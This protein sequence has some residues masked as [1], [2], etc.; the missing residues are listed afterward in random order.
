LKKKAEG[1][2][3]FRKETAGVSVVVTELD[4]S[5]VMG[6][7]A[8]VVPSVSGITIDQDRGLFINLFKFMITCRPILIV[9]LLLSFGCAPS[10]GAST[11]TP[12]LVSAAE[13]AM[14]AYTSQFEGAVHS[15]VLD[16]G[17]SMDI[18]K[19][20][21]HFISMDTTPN[22]QVTF[23]IAGKGKTRSTGVG[24]VQF[25]RFNLTTQSDDVITR[26]N[27]AFCPDSPYN[28][29]SLNSLKTDG[30][31]IND[32]DFVLYFSNENETIYS[33]QNHSYQ[34]E[35][36]TNHLPYW[37]Y[38][39]EHSAF[40]ADIDDSKSI[41]Q[42]N[43][44]YV[45]D[46]ADWSILRK[47]FDLL[48][49]E[50]GPFNMEAFVDD[51]YMNAHLDE[52][53]CVTKSQ[54]SFSVP[55][56]GKNVY[57]NMPF[58]SVTI[59]KTLT[60]GLK[61]FQ[62]SPFDT[63][64]CFVVPEWKNQRWYGLTKYFK[65]VRRYE[66]GSN[67]FTIPASKLTTDNA[68]SVDGR[69]SVGPTKWPVLVLYKDWTTP[70]KIDNEMLAHLRFGHYNSRQLLALK[71]SKVVTGLGDLSSHY[72]HNDLYCSVCHEWKDIRLSPNRNKTRPG[73][74]DKTGNKVEKQTRTRSQH[75]GELTFSDVW[76]PSPILSETGAKYVIGFID[77]A[78]R[79]ATIYT[80]KSKDEVPMY[81]AKYRRYQRSLGCTSAKCD[82]T[83][84]LQTDNDSV[85]TSEKMQKLGADE[86]F[87]LRHSAPYLHENNSIIER[88]WRTLNDRS[89]CMLATGNLA[90]V[91][92]PFAWRHGVWLYN[93]LPHS[94]L[95]GISPHEKLHGRPA[96]LSNVKI[97]GTRCFSF[98][99]ASLRNKTEPHSVFGYYM[100]H[101]HNSDPSILFFNPATN[102]VSPVGS[103]TFHEN[104]TELSKL[105]S[106]PFTQTNFATQEN[107][108]STALDGPYT[109]RKK[110][111]VLDSILE[112]TV[113]YDTKDKENFGVLKVNCSS[114]KEPTWVRLQTVLDSDLSNW[115]VYEAY[116]KTAYSRG[117][118]RQNVHFPIFSKA[119]YLATT[120]ELLYGYISS[121]D[122]ERDLPF[123][124]TVLDED[125][126][127]GISS[128]D[129]TAEQILEFNST[130][131]SFVASNITTQFST[132]V[133]PKSMAHAQTYPDHWES[134]KAAIAKELNSIS[135]L[136]VLSP[137]TN[138]TEI[139]GKNIV[140][141][142]W[143]F[144][145]KR[146][147]DGSIDRYKARCVAQGYSQKP[148]EDFD[149]T[150]A[151]VS[152]LQSNRHFI[153]LALNN[154][155]SITQH[156]VGTAFLNSEE[157]EFDIVVR[158]PE[159][160]E[161][162]GHTYFWLKKSLYGLKQAAHRWYQTINT[163][164]LEHDTRLK[165]NG[166]DPCLYTIWGKEVKVMVLVYVDDILVATDC[167]EWREKF[168][169][170]VQ[171]QFKLT[172]KPSVD[173]LCGVDINYNLSAGTC[174]FS[175]KLEISDLMVAYSIVRTKPVNSP[176]SASFD[177]S[178]VR[179]E[180]EKIP[181]VPY[182][183]LLGSLLWIARN[184]RPD[185]M[186]ATI[187]LSGYTHTH[188]MYHWK[189]MIR[190]VEYLDTT[191]ELELRYTKMKDK[192]VLEKLKDIVSL[193]STRK[194][195][196][197]TMC[198]ATGNK[199]S[200]CPIEQF[201]DSDWATCKVSR[202]S[203]SGY[204]T[205]VYGNLTSWTCQ[206]QSI[207]AQSSCEAEYIAAASAVKDGC[208]ACNSLGD[209]FPS[210]TETALRKPNSL[211][212]IDNQGAIHVALNDVNN[213]RTKHIDLRHHMIREK[214]KDNFAISKV[215]TDDNVSD[216]FT[217]P[218]EGAKFDKFVSMLGLS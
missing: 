107:S 4:D 96:D 135:D 108:V 76:G 84:K 193:K 79:W 126:P 109:R 30:C 144:D 145:I 91:L 171:G 92:W 200:F 131:Y 204:C 28:L 32:E 192:T 199:L 82:F 154:N 170:A 75:F 136:D 21:T 54:D 152:Q 134:W 168:I 12:M 185:I 190:V 160:M 34:I 143:I 151:P 159:K 209:I 43:G 68:D 29:T 216:V 169:S 35:Y 120:G 22:A 179:K 26:E 122:P 119:T 50:L 10:V 80:M 180:N 173:R 191:K 217:K 73:H 62:E 186:T 167:K 127:D 112:H 5:D 61:E 39:G 205:Y 163:F 198:I 56:K 101:P 176:M 64:L 86:G 174:S 17:C 16:S 41:N 157:T 210:V 182:K 40:G 203:I 7:C 23:A 42:E 116:M 77:D 147:S 38:Y 45:P 139:E 33:K 36:G 183:S 14:T 8:D 57:G 18:E 81:V 20:A 93:R 48:N 164:I 27:V 141:C 2:K 9:L 117:S 13:A 110:I 118:F 206:K 133:M 55:W 140:N 71:E 67:L 66:K 188:T 3:P 142:R 99:D 1:K 132:Y 63:S 187:I 24:V 98:I 102:K 166:S 125:S 165:R 60:Y 172:S 105:I 95:R 100:G 189:A 175:Q 46:Q 37:V 208:Y 138:L 58:D 25:S 161:F 123:C 106:D 115:E 65:V 85:Y 121:T 128:V 149:K 19:E 153:S 218:L 97:F 211:L 196:E 113:L 207:V 214:L 146:L 213:N 150:F 124:I 15:S 31:V 184:S 59:E 197:K 51:S 88:L 11:E 44:A 74:Y 178:V 137:V 156:D 111:G 181:D 130:E 83:F 201:S 103:V 155:M 47:E 212:K 89:N 202:K 195:F 70:V 90:K 194:L 215:H 72:F 114:F 6:F 148:G 52:E 87:L 129:V 69:F 104:C 78:T 94:S 53:M 162:E 158:L 49:K 177:T